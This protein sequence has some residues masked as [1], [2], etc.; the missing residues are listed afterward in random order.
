[1]FII[2]LFL[3]EFDPE[4]KMVKNSEGDGEIKCV[5][6]GPSTMPDLGGRILVFKPFSLS[7]WT[8]CRRPRG[9]CVFTLA[10]EPW[11]PGWHRK[12]PSL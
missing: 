3:S 9:Q 6:T 7:E 12:G 2:I 5:C 10:V 8:R 11:V 1:M 4:N